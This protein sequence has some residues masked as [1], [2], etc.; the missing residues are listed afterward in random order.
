LYVKLKFSEYAVPKGNK[1]L[2]FKFSYW[3]KP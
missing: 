2:K 1:F 3:A